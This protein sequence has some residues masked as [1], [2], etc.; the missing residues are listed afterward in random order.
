MDWDKKIN[1]VKEIMKNCTLCEFRCHIDRLSSQ[2]EVCKLDANTYYLRDFINIW[3]ELGPIPCYTILFN[4]C[5]FKCPY[6]ILGHMIQ[7][8]QMG[9][10]FHP[11]EFIKRI[12]IIYE[13]GINNIIFLGGEPVVHLLS[14][15]KVLKSLPPSIKKNLYSYLYLPEKTVELLAGSFDLFLAEYRYG[16]DQCAM[17]YSA[18]KN[19]TGTIQKNLLYL[20]SSSK[21]IIRHLMLPGHM[22][23]CYRPMVNWL[24][25]NMP[26]VK[27]SLGNEYIPV[28]KA[29]H[30]PEI[31][32]RVND[33]EYQL[34]V[35]IAK[36]VGLELICRY[37]SREGTSYKSYN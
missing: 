8:P 2:A 30:F 31:N 37:G 14:L 26:E 34:A 12:K 11:E 10:L 20:K 33:L 1:E 7:K 5:C 23:C 24:A 35:S 3:E 36:E 17:K 32:R 25:E 21:V 28:Y 22:E 27:L 18:A 6:C 15:F 13:N 4:G 16:S 29:R 19:Y 9:F